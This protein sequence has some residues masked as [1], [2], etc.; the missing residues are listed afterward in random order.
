MVVAFEGW[1]DAATAATSAVDHLVEH[2]DAEPIARID[3]ERFIDFQQVRPHVS[4]LD[5][6]TRHIVWPENV[7][8]ATT[9]SESGPELVL[10]SGVEPHYLWRDFAELLL[11]V[12]ARTTSTVI[13]TLGSTAAQTPH[14]RMPMVHASSTNDELAT[15]FG[16]D[17]P[18]YQGITG[19]IGVLHAACEQ[20]GVPAIS[21]QVGVPHYATGASNP[22]AAMALL[23]N[24]EHITGVPTGSASLQASV[25][26]WEAMV[27][28][29]ISESPE[30]LSYVPQLEARYDQDAAAAIPSS[31]DL[32]AEFERY[33]RDLDAGTDTDS[34]TDSD[35][36]A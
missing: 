26:E 11:D 28:N 19:I 30:A 32:A 35:S 34:G 8:H 22:K 15:R 23:R 12:S 33:L 24:L 1:F 20:R 7:V 25:T 27:D 31:D 6:G 36:D 17:R 13:V 9:G 14:T 5:D 29:A 10:V 3:S 4:N 21:M 16:L 2:T 18:R